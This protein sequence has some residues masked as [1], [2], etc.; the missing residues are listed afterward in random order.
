M[1]MAAFAAFGLQKYDDVH[2]LAQQ[3]EKEAH[4]LRDLHSLLN[5]A[6]KVGD[7]PRR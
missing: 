1:T 6:G 3:I 2:R 5:A 4:A 7:D